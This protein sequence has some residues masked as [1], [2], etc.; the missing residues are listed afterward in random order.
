MSSEYILNQKPPSADR[1]LHYGIDPNQFGDLR[2]PS[3]DGPFPVVMNI[4]GGFWRAAYNLE[5]AGHL[6][7]ALAHKGIATWNVEYRRVGNPGGSWPGTADDIT[8]SFKY[9]QHN[10][11]DLH[12]DAKRILIMGHSAG[13]HLAFWLAA[14]TPAVT[15]VVGL[16]GVLDLQEAWKLH[17]SNDAVVELLGG[18]PT[19][20]PQHYKAADPVHLAIPHAK[21]WVV[22]GTKDDI[23]PIEISQSYV[24]SK[25][26]EHVEFCGIPDA[27]HFDIVDPKSQAWN[28][29]ER[30]IVEN[31]IHG[32]GK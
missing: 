3:G 2:L 21:Q 28:V 15:R 14:N 23:V 7:A 4:H 1:R 22:H 29:I 17:L 26:S 30:I 20:V 6:C 19:E 12:V 25:R 24:A 10:C 11:D 8:A 32:S 31:L 18:T 16:A 27:D 5:Y 9:L 13:G